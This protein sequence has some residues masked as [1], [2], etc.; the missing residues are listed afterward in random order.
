MDYAFAPGVFAC[1][2]DGRLVVLNVRADRYLMLPPALEATLFRMIEKREPV[3]GDDAVC[4]RLCTNGL[5]LQRAATPEL[6]LCSAVPPQRS[7]IDEGWSSPG[8]GPVALAGM[9]AILARTRLSILGL[10]RA[11]DRVRAVQC[12][13]ASDGDRVIRAAV[14]FAELRFTMRALGRCL[15]LSLALASTAR[16]RH[17]E[18]R[19]VLG[20][21]CDPFLAHA[22]V[23]LHA[24]VLNDRLDTVRSFT[25]I[26]VL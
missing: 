23:E 1:V 6:A 20:V 2:A 21:Q 14:A 5:V 4:E 7:L 15:P 3:A 24:K 8:A 12:A 18:V 10:E 19:L 22:W 17:S 25:P 26:L 16:R 11:L 13:C 9:S